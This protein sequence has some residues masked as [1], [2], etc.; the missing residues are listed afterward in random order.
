[1][2]LL[3]GL[4]VLLSLVGCTTRKV[5]EKEQERVIKPRPVDAPPKA[6]IP[7]LSPEKLFE[8]A[9]KAFDLKDFNKSHDYFIASAGVW[10]GKAREPEAL[11]WANRALVRGGRYHEAIDLT[12]SLLTSRR[13]N[14]TITAELYNHL[15]RSF[16]SIG[17][18]MNAFVTG[19]EALSQ[20][21]L[22]KD[23]E[24]FKVK[25]NE[26]IENKMTF[27]ELSKVT[28]EER[29][30]EFRTKSLV[31]LAEIS[32][33]EKD[34]DGARNYLGRAVSLSP[35]SDSGFKAKDYLNQLES[36]RKVEPKTVGVVLP[37]SGRH[38]AVSQKTLRGI[39]MGLGLYNNI[40]TSFKLAVVDSEGNPDMA[41]RG[42]ERLVKE[43]NVIAVIGSLL[44]RTAPAVAAKT[45][46]LGVPSIALSQKAGIT[47]AGP[48][49]F[50]NA[51]TSEM[52]VRTLVKTAMEQMG[53]KKFAVIYPNDLYGVEFTNLFWDEVLARGGKIVAAQTYSPKETDFRFLVQRLVGTYYIESRSEEYKF[54]LKE[55]SDA[56][57]KITSRT[58]PPEDLLPPIVD[59]DAV[60]IPDN[61]KTMGQI[62]AMLSF[63]GVKGVKL[64][65]TNLWNTEGT[66]KR[67][68]HFAKDLLFVDSFLPQDVSVS[69][70]S[71]IQE[72][73]TIFGEEPGVFELQG[74]DSA[75]LVRQLIS[76]GNSNRESLATAL[77]QVKNFPGAVGLLSMSAE[78]EILRPVIALTLDTNGLVV[79]LK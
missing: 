76:E 9:R 57:K 24:S 75:L 43:D 69:T 51:L 66:S 3:I 29:F 41:R 45:S 47:E 33:D 5:K 2:K 19:N 77:S 34:F 42:V 23:A 25:L 15:Y 59:F 10:A 44:S 73:K 30:G 8:A 52:Q 4:L 39:Q 67:A 12:K 28:Q 56:Q 53:L 21:A 49:V 17:D 11:L 61:V 65:G 68:G 38:A 36:L 64:I 18:V 26:L 70:S 60:F 35:S 50:R 37:M 58:T 71:F 62:S 40:P 54:R 48:S 32:I 27:A 46:E 22:V 14:E 20:P 63:N 31:R 79:P 6:Q 13:W 7:N 78:K 55:W 74:Y 1:M 72:Y 16:E